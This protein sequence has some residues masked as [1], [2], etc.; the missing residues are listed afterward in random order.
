LSLELKQVTSRAFAVQKRLLL[1]AGIK[2]HLKTLKSRL[3]PVGAPQ[4]GHGFNRL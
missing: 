3:K 4:K 2:R 1:P